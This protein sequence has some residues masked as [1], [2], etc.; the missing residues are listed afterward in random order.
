MTDPVHPSAERVRAAVARG[1][2]R[3]AAQI[4]K[5]ALKSDPR[6]DWA[7][8]DLTQVLFT[9]GRH[10]DAEQVARTAL[11]I[12]PD[13]AQAHNLFGTILSEFNDLPSGEW[14]FRRALELGG[15]QARFAANL[16]LNLMQQGRTEE[17]EAH[18]A[19]AVAQAPGDAMTLAQW[20]K[21][22]EV[23]GELERAQELL[24]RAKRSASAGNV[25]LLQASHLV[26]AR[27]LEEALALLEA[28]PRLN[29]DA[30]LERG[31]LYDRLGRY[32]D[33]WRDFVD[34]KAAL[35]AEKG[36][37]VYQREAVETFFGR[38]KHFFTEKNFARLPRAAVR[39]GVPQPIFVMG[40][41]RSGT[42]L[43]EQVLASHSTVRAGGELAFI[44]EIRKLANLLF[45][46]PEPFPDNLGRAWTADNHHVATLFRDH[47]FA[48]AEQAGLLA[49]SESFFTDKMPF[50]EIWLPLVRM[51]FPHA[52]IV[53]VVRHPLDVCVSMLANN[54]THGF[55]CGYRIE[56]IAHHVAAV[57][58][59]LEHYRRE[60]DLG[61]YEVRYEAF[62]TGQ[63]QQTGQ[64]LEHLGLDFEEACISFH[65][66]RRYARTPSYVQVAEKL[67][68][69]SIHRHRHYAAQLAPHVPMLAR[70]ITALGDDE[71]RR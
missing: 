18:F 63:R 55:N 37:L 50:N 68:D 9:M 7:Y 24:D 53:R 35:A 25:D 54:L 13:N 28:A 61:W 49:G 11:R 42:T 65:E 44:G 29:G 57:S 14:H 22:C 34:G 45:V 69:A 60:L 8:N 56:D 64:L 71:K 36:G 30:H 52:K 41:P 39:N 70:I 59:L 10:A 38:L 2:L 21:L 27:R 4:L 67:N 1:G 48:R 15:P 40:F 66:N 32:G 26:R 20:S 16:A 31:R 62:V 58:D 43:I 19:A 33:A 23:R 46:G 5:E 6:A 17:A 47:Y 51:A 3:E 12:N